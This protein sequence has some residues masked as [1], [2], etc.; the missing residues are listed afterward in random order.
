MQLK[1][2]SKKILLD[3]FSGLPLSGEVWAYGSR[4]MHTAHD[5]SDLD[6]V[7]VT[8]DR[9]KLPIDVLME[10]KEKIRESN[11]PILVDLFDWARLPESFQKNI[12]AAHEVLYRSNIPE[13]LEPLEEYKTNI[14]LN[15]D[16]PDL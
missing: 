10:L 13:L 3:I 8:P 11:I 4:T 6:L 16:L 2:K 5:G 14:Y 1:N 15:H 9:R 7:I 12:D